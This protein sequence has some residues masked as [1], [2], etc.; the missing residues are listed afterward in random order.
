MASPF[1]FNA[2]L[3]GAIGGP[4]RWIESQ[5][6]SDYSAQVAA[7]SAFATAV[8]AVIASPGTNLEAAAR[9]LTS[10]CQAFWSN[11]LPQSTSPASYHDAAE[12]V[13]TEFA[14]ALADLEAEGGTP[15]SGELIVQPFIA[16]AAQTVFTLTSAPTYPANVLF[17]VNGVSYQIGTD[18]TVAAVTV[19]WLNVD[20]I[21][22][23]GDAVDIAY[24]L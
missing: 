23:T 24:Q 8:D 9:L 3:S 22:G 19:T 16:T 4:Q 18:F 12:A 15:G 13:A 21:L 11:R 7:A 6:P 2:A 14:D 5:A 20:F 1:I 17:F 10:I